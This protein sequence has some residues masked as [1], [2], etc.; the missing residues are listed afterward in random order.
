M[1]ID[2]FSLGLLLHCYVDLEKGFSSLELE[3]L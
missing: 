3:F 1:D 2:L